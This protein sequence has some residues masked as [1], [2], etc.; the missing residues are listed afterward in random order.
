[1]LR[2]TV[3]G[4]FVVL[5]VVTAGCP[6]DGSTAPPVAGTDGGGGGDGGSDE[7]ATV[8][9]NRTAALA[10]AGRYTSTWRIRSGE[11]GAIV[12]G[13]GYVTATDYANERYSFGTTITNGAEVRTAVASYYA[14]GREYQRIGDGDPA[15][16]ASSEDEPTRSST[17]TG[18][19]RLRRGRPGEF[20][21]GLTGVGST[22]VA[23]PAWFAEALLAA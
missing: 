23:E 9:E 22:D 7:A 5:L 10:A 15:A 18:G 11:D 2:S 12:G 14:D 20:T 4:A 16:Y 21:Y 19:V 3:L 6:G 8:V 13:I 1:M 17:R